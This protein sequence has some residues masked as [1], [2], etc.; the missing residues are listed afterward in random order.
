MVLVLPKSGHDSSE[1]TKIVQD[2]ILRNT[3]VGDQQTFKIFGY[4]LVHIFFS[5]NL[6]RH[7]ILNRGF[8]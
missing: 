6:N 4:V 3:L 5:M 2:I 7:S 8:Y 1:D